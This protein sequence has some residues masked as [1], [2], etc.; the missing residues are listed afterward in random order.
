[1]I[2]K[3]IMNDLSSFIIPL[4]AISKANKTIKKK[5]LIGSKA[6]GLGNLIEMGLN[7]PAGFVVTTSLYQKDL[8][9]HKP[10]ILRM[11]DDLRLKNVSVRSSANVEDSDKHS[12][13]GQFET[14]LNINKKN[15]LQTIKKCQDSVNTARVK[16]Y[17]K[18]KNIDFKK[19]K[20][21]VIVQ[22]MIEPETAGVCFTINPI[23]NNKN[24]LMI[25]AVYGQGEGVVSGKI[26]DV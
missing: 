23:D 17:S 10:E 12:F 9:D 15:L 13:A 18:N 5:N 8:G 11:F 14:F 25:N 20:M 6:V 24:Q 7:V 21:A 1:M 4:D 26:I 2:D 16:E 19:I 22:D 3:A